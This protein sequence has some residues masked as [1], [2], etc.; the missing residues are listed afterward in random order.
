MICL[1]DNFGRIKDIFEI[2]LNG[3]TEKTKIGNSLDIF[4]IY[5]NIITSYYKN[6]ICKKSQ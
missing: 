4:Y 3:E 6:L 1:N 5:A 2:N